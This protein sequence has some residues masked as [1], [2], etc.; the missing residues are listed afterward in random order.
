MLENLQKLVGMDINSLSEVLEKYA[1][2]DFTYK[3]DEKTS[4]KIGVDIINMNNMITKI[5]QDNQEDGHNLQ[6]RSSQLT[7]NV[8]VLNENAS[9]QAASLEETA[10]SIEEI[11]GNIKQTSE[12]DRLALAV[13]HR[14][15]A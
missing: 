7:S 14:S 5:L 6:T 15:L 3:L 11:T 1:K 4:G 13:A 12:K 10:A 8:K 2:R 9:S